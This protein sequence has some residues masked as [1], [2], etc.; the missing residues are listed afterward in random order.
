VTLRTREPDALL[1]NRLTY[2]FIAPAMPPGHDWS[3]PVGTGPYR[4]VSWQKGRAIEATAFAE[5]WAGRPTFELVEFQ[6]RP[7]GDAGLAALRAGAVDVLRYVPEA[8]ADQV[9]QVPGYRLEAHAGLQSFYLWFDARPAAGPF[10]DRRV[11][12]AA[13]LA[14]DRVELVRRLGSHGAAA[15]QFV[16]QG[17]YGHVTGLPEL[18]H[19]PTAARRLLAEAGYPHG[20]EIALAH[21]ASASTAAVAEQIRAQLGAVGI[22]IRLLTPEWTQMIADWKAQRLPFFLAG[23]YFEN[24]DAM[25]FF[26]DCLLTQAPRGGRGAF[27]PGYSNP[28]LDRLVD[29]ATAVVS[30]PEQLDQFRKLTVLALEDMPLVPLYHR[31][32]LYAVRDDLRWSPRLDGMLLAVEM[33]RTP[34]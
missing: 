31:E 5:H 1:A 23:W 2:A 18:H 25:S 14:I 30:R 27:N 4:F 8:L 34:Y 15:Q 29:S 22:Q 26:R 19:D 7:E 3:T 13:S 16:H 6:L 20:F 28:E 32:N 17:V 10:A 24:G 12:Q 21:R 33:S 11:R 9:A